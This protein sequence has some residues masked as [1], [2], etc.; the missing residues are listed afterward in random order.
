LY[1]HFDRER[2]RVIQ[3]T[4]GTAD[5]LRRE[6]QH[7]TERTRPVMRRREQD[8]EF[9]TVLPQILAINLAYTEQALTEALKTIFPLT[10]KTPHH[11]ITTL[12]M[13][14]SFGELSHHPP[15]FQILLP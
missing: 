7:T 11:T 10:I 2:F 14:L 13:G 8:E 3:K 6:Q 15:V 4:D 5:R 1:G 12:S 9:F